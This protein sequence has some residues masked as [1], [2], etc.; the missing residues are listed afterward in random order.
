MSEIR[1]IKR[2][3]NRKLYDMVE[4]KYVALE[5]IGNAIKSGETVRV[6]D[7]K[8]NED[9]TVPTLALLLYEGEKTAKVQ[10]SVDLLNRIIRH[11]DGSF[12]GYIQTKLDS[13]VPQVMPEFD[14]PQRSAL[15]FAVPNL[16]N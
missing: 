15:T 11:G 2:Y 12:T 3:P 13:D 14:A 16:N 7:N 4:R 10:P 6:V 9:I 1:I 5:D 8:T